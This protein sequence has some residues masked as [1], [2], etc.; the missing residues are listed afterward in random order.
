MATK[1]VTTPAG[2]DATVLGYLQQALEDLDKARE[3][4]GG[5][6]RERIDAAGER[7]RTTVSDLRRRAEETVEDW[8]QML[9]RSTEELRRDLAVR[10]VHAQQT[11]AAL[12]VVSREIRKRRAELAAHD[13]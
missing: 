7:I 3:K 4:A 6:A 10:A 5:D 9:D 2:T 12:T 11:E 8:E 13:A 1:T